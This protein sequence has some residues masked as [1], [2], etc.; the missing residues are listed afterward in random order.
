MKMSFEFK[1]LLRFLE[2][3]M[4]WT[5]EH[6]AALKNIAKPTGIKIPKPCEYDRN[7]PLIPKSL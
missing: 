3:A 5:Y 1:V 4:P 2:G 6:Y 7:T